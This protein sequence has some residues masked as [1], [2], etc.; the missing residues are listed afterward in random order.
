MAIVDGACNVINTQ[1][2]RTVFRP[3]GMTQSG[4]YRNEPPIERLAT[5]YGVMNGRVVPALPENDAW[6]F[7][8]G[9]IYSTIRDLHL[10]NVFLMRAE[11]PIGQSNLDLMFTRREGD[12]GY[13]IA[14]YRQHD[15]DIFGHGGATDGFSSDQ[16]ESKRDKLI[17][18]SLHNRNKK[19]VINRPRC[20]SLISILLG[21]SV[22]SLVK[23]DRIALN[24]DIRQLMPGLYRA[25]G[26]TTQ[27][28]IRIEGEEVTLS[29]EHPGFHEQV[30]EHYYLTVENVF[31]NAAEYEQVAYSL[32]SN[33]GGAVFGGLTK[34]TEN[35]EGR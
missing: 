7:S 9:G 3:L 30:I 29:F 34:V 13:G 21:E 16:R 5:G 8:S 24:D 19:Y 11:A 26:L 1:L 33:T 6:L 4:V 25:D 31:Q 22:T 23:P 35:G 14:E 27:F 15:R 17:V 10:W 32:D 2:A 20:S 28:R 18:L 12:S